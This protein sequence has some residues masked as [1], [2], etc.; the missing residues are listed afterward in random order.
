VKFSV[1]VEHRHPTKSPEPN[2]S[3]FAWKCNLN[4]GSALLPRLSS[5]ANASVTFY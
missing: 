3:P 1:F 4:V 5:I 2:F